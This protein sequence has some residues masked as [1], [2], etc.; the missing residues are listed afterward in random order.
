MIFQGL[1]KARCSHLFPI[2]THMKC[3]FSHSTCEWNVFPLTQSL[4]IIA[5][6]DGWCHVPKWQPLNPNE[7]VFSRAP[8]PSLPFTLQ[9][10]HTHPL[11]PSGEAQEQQEHLLQQHREL[12]KLV[13]V[14]TLVI[15][16]FHFTPL[17]STSPEFAH[18]GSQ[19]WGCWWPA[20]KIVFA[21]SAKEISEEFNFSRRICSCVI[22]CYFCPWKSVLFPHSCVDLR[23]T[24]P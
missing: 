8:A 9:N 21:D 13:L 16:P 4:K 7:V 17:S 15:Q 5:I 11:S 14:S 3:K 6:P 24:Q 22:K 10:L 18:A 19:E 20:L 12:W 23:V 1:P 2:H